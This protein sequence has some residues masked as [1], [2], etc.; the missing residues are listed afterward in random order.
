MKTNTSLLFFVTLYSAVCIV[1]FL[2]IFPNEVNT[3]AFH[4]PNVPSLQQPGFEFLQKKSHLWL[5]NL[6][7]LIAKKNHV[8]EALAIIL[9]ILV[10]IAGFIGR[11]RSEMVIINFVLMG[12]L[13]VYAGLNLLLLDFLFYTG[14]VEFQT[15]SVH[16]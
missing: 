8:R 10:L 9:S 12:I 5:Y 6:L 3:L 1:L 13:L 2:W 16:G 15:E 11:K 14:D 4:L 7:L